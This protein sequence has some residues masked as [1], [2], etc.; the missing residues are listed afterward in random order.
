MIFLGIIGCILLTNTDY[1]IDTRQSEQLKDKDMQEFPYYYLGVFF[2]IAFTIL[3]A[4]KF[5]AIRELGNMVHSSVKTFWFGTFS[6]VLTALFLVVYDP[7]IFEL[8]KIGSPDY[9]LDGSQFVGTLIIGFF[10]WGG[11]ESLSLALT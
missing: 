8:W 5:L 9:P 10:S 3:N 11:Q 7:S 2:A 1:F 4:L 6:T